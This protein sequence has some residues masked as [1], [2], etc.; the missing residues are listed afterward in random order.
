ML[1]LNWNQHRFDMLSF[2]VLAALIP[3]PILLHYTQYN[4][5]KAI[6]NLFLPKEIYIPNWTDVLWSV[7]TVEW[8]TR[9]WL[10]CHIV[11]LN[12]LMP[13]IT[14]GFLELRSLKTLLNRPQESQGY[15]KNQKDLRITTMIRFAASF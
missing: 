15:Q 4:F 10:C 3:V 14:L 6:S 11:F 1:V 2:H 5:T 8:N 12:N 7:D 13:V 9:H